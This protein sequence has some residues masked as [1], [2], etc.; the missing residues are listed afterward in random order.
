MMTKVSGLLGSTCWHRP[1]TWSL[2]NLIWEWSK[3][4][5]SQVE[6]LQKRT[7]LVFQ[8]QQEQLKLFKQLTRMV[9]E[10]ILRNVFE[11]KFDLAVL[12]ARLRVY[13]KE[14]DHKVA[15]HDFTATTTLSSFHRLSR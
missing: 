3:S 15:K 9:Q 1:S 14:L 13:V 8:V 2:G 6:Q 10:V 7:N 4:L 11:D 5:E 12:L